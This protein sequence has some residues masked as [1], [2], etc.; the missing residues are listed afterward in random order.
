MAQAKLFGEKLR[1]LRHRHKLT[2][3]A[4]ARALGLSSHGHITNVEAGRRTPSV[5]LAI[6]VATVFH[7]PLDFLLQDRISPEGSVPEV[8]LNL[9]ITA[10]RRSFGEKLRTFRQQRNMT[11]PELAK[12]LGLASQSHVA[13]FEAGRRMPSVEVLLRATELLGMTADALLGQTTTDAAS[14]DNAD[15]SNLHCENNRNRKSSE[16]Q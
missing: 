16:K 1:T 11:Q 8:D 5:D 3:L 13:N 14:E 4:L 12:I 9:T 7:V 2:Q 10:A 6:R 15:D